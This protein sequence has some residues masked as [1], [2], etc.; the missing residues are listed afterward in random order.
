MI[1]IKIASWPGL[2]RAD[3][4]P[5]SQHHTFHGL[6]PADTAPSREAAVMWII[7]IRI[8]PARGQIRFAQ[9]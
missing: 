8:T 1:R 6:L 4:Q 9:N 7:L 3:V 5:P 2:V